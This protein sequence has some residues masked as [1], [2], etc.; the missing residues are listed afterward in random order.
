MGRKEGEK[1]VSVIPRCQVCGE[2]MENAIDTI[3]GEVSPYLWKTT[4]KHGKDRI[5]CIG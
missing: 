3:T 5:L 2:L 1:M 4:C